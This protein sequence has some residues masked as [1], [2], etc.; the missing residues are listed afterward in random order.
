MQRDHAP[1]RTLFLA[2]VVLVGGFVLADFVR[3]PLLPGSGAAAVAPPR[4]TLWVPAS[5]TDGEATRLAERAAAGFDLAGHPAVV[6]HLSGA[7]SG[8]LASLLARRPRGR[9]SDLLVLSSTTLT[10]LA[11]DRSDRLVPGAAGEAVEA[12]TL[13][14]HSRPLALLSQE[15]LALGAAPGSGIRRS[16]QLAEMVRQ[17]PSGS[18]FGIADDG[19]SRVQL[20]A[21][22]NAIGSGGSVLFTPSGSPALAVQ[23]VESGRATL[24]M[25]AQSAVQAGA[26]R[27]QL[28]RVAW[29]AAAGGAPD[30]WVALVAPGQLEHSGFAKLRRWVG[31]L[32]RE[33]HWRAQL[34][35]GGQLP[36]RIP[37]R[38]NLW[39]R[40]SLCQALEAEGLANSLTRLPN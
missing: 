3:S 2:L 4:L 32:V 1:G 29:P 7:T 6:K 18:I 22:V 38:L 30:F 12:M 13:L 16:S 9:G 17:D 36:T 10:S 33:P 11:R 25:A 20:A 23:T 15:P 19:F 28:N 26:R 39:L 8:A 24:V 21:L 40:K 31:A 14:R 35:E 37:A 34:R 5:E 27:K